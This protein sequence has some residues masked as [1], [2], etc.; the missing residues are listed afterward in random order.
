[1]ILAIDMGNTNIVVGGIDENNTYFLERVLTRTDSTA[2]EWALTFNDLFGFVGY[3]PED[4]EGAI[5]ASVVPQ[6]NKAVLSGLTKVLGYT[7]INVTYDMNSG[8]KYGTDNPSETGP[9]L[10]AG[11]VAAMN[12]Y[13]LPLAVIDL[14][15]ATTIS[16]V[17]SDC[18]FQ[19]A[20]IHP[21]IKKSLSAM[22]DSASLLPKIDISHIESAL[23]RNT[24]DCMKSG[25]LYG[26]AGMIDGC[27]N[28][29]EKELGYNLN[30]I[31]T[32]GLA[33]YVAELCEHDITVDSSLLLKGLLILYN[34]N[35]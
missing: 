23:G 19:G 1:M 32:G 10:I 21:G 17:D 12:E 29:I 13:P 11:M 9:D 34:M 7:P 24:I 28:N 6:A 22:T 27:L 30:V 26:H 15:T 4:F 2:L 31:A 3:K 35:K 18:T 16:I 14:G 33:G 25:V 8:L 20:V 5:M